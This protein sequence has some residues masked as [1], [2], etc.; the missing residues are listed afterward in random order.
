MVAV[1]KMLQ[2]MSTTTTI[3]KRMALKDLRKD[4]IERLHQ[5]HC[6]L[7]ATQQLAQEKKIKTCQAC[8]ENSRNQQKEPMPVS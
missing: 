5:I 4:M 7:E 2:N 3:A 8:F 6:G 1:Q